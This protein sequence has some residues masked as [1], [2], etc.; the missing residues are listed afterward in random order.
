MTAQS[1][2]MIG[3]AEHVD[4]HSA[5]P[6]PPPDPAVLET[7]PVAWDAFVARGPGTTHL[8]TTGWANVKRANGWQAR[9]VALNVSGAILGSQMLI[10]RAGRLPWRIGYVARGPIGAALTPANLGPLTQ[11]LREQ[12]RAEGLAYLVFEPE[13]E[14]DIGL[15]ARFEELGW[16]RTSHVQPEATRVIDLTQPIERLEAEMRSKWRQ[17]VNK[18]RRSG[19]RLVEGGEDRLDDFYRIY[20]DAYRRAGVTSR[21]RESFSI[22]WR[23]L[24]P[25]G[26]AHLLLAESG[27]PGEPQ[28][29]LLLVSAG[30][31]VA[32]V[33]GGS[34]P[35]GNVSRANYLL[36]WEAIAHFRELGFTEYDMYG[37]PHAG[38][39]HFKAG[40]GGREIHYVG[41]WE[42]VVDRLGGAVLAAGNGLRLRYV[43]LRYGR[44]A[45][46]RG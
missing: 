35:A 13:A 1:E 4:P 28:A 33:Y 29:A 21:S 18:A 20:A 25:R 31:R 12:A 43:R 8:Q 15:E 32:E 38:I 40:F 27:D 11:R 37:I 19:I 41:A 6:A 39:A 7:D 9:R 5:P 14:T 34:T 22:L 26:M 10:R 2:T 36:K 30:T 16:R 44:S 23:E 17:Y 24:A 3:V 45:E 42:L 46:R